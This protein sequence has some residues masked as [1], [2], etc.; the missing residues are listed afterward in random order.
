M[1]YNDVV[2]TNDCPRDVEVILLV[3]LDRLPVESPV[4]KERSVQICQQDEA[5]EIT[6]AS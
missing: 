4:N 5:R 1:R 2:A 3:K 6:F